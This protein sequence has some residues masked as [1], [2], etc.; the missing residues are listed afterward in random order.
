MAHKSLE[1]CKRCR[2]C[3]QNSPATLENSAAFGEE[4]LKTVCF[5]S[6]ILISHYSKPVFLT[7]LSEFL[8]RE[9][10]VLSRVR[11]GNLSS[12]SRHPL[13]YDGI[14]EPD[15]IDAQRQ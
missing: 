4:I 14:K 5:D 1:I 2:L 15:H 10:Q 6:L 8:Y 11:C 13:W 9:L 12:D 3:Q 7:D